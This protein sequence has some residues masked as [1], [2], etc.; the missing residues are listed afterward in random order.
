MNDLV[1]YH[2]QDR[3]IRIIEKD[4]EPQLVCK[5]I[6]ETLEYAS[7][8]MVQI[9]SHVP[10]EWKGSN[11]IT[12]PGGVQE[13][14]CISEQ[15]LYFFLGRSDKPMALP[16][17][18]WIAGEVVPSIRKKGFYADSQIAG[19]AAIMVKIEKALDD[20]KKAAYAELEEWLGKTVEYEDKPMHKVYVHQLYHAY[21]I[22]LVFHHMR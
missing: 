9:F 8:N 17:Q 4:G 16:F 20:P 22:H 12:T 11:P 7:T 13:M 18:K 19:L 10:E 2:F 14:L 21:R 3:E 1:N 5:D 6:A 15:G